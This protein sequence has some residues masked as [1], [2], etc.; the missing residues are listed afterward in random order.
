MAK[1]KQDKSFKKTVIFL[2]LIIAIMASILMIQIQANKH[3]DNKEQE[4]ISQ[5]LD[6]IDIPQ[7]RIT[8]EIPERCL[9]VKQLQQ[10]N[11]DVV[12]W[13]EI[14]GT[15][16]NY[17]I[18]Q[19]QDNDYYLKHTYKKESN[20][21]G[22]IFLDKDYD[23]TKPSSNLLIYG[24]RNTKGIMFEDLI[25]YKD[26]SF[27]Q[28]HKT[29]RFTTAKEDSTYEILAAFNSRV[30][31]QDEQNVFR[32]YQFV[33]ANNRQEFDEY[34][35]NAKESS[36]YDTNKIAVYGEQL[37]TLST[38]NYSQTNGRFAVVAVKVK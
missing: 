11:P 7:E 14:Q 30:Y 9:Q 3:K 10:E 15:N 21:S 22:S 27:Y 37:L 6:T 8:P 38:C 32:Y 2:L 23:F 18:L 28:E 31:Y 25:K 19:G 24:H 16:I 17:P 20:S 13:L 26:E 29:I 5:V 33:N 12:A 35:R 36:L 4:Q 34:V 1:H